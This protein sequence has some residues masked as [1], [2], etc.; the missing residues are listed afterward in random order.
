MPGNGWNQGSPP[1]AQNTSG[2][3]TL[4][5]ITFTSGANSGLSYVIQDYENPGSGGVITLVRGMLA[6]PAP[7]DTF[8]IVAG[9]DKAYETCINKFSNLANFAGAPWVPTPEAMA[10]GAGGQGT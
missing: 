6:T 2:F 8:T 7:G 4:G 10:G 5:V 3:F 1:P 9:C